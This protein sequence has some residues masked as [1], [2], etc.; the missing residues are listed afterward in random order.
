[1]FF[2]ERCPEPC[3]VQWSGYTDCHGPCGTGDG[4]R[5][6]TLTITKQPIPAGDCIIGN[7]SFMIF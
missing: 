2:F 1:M 7:V 4:T 3:E 5:T 6:R